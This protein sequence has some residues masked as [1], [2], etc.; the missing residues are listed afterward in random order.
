MNDFER[1][2]WD[3][4]QSDIGDEITDREDFAPDEQCILVVGDPSAF[5]YYGPFLCDADAMYAAET[6]PTIRDSDWWIMELTPIEVD[7]RDFGPDPFG[8]EP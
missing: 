8:D 1:A 4:R 5:K 2:D 3:Q 7:V 6:D